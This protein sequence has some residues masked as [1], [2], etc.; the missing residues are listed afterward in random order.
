M[1]ARPFT[2][3]VAS[4]ASAVP[5]AGGRDVGVGVAVGVA[6]AVG[7]GVGVAVGVGVGVGV[8]VAV[9]AASAAGCSVADVDTDAGGA[10]SGGR[11]APYTPVPVMTTAQ[12][13]IVTTAPAA[14]PFSPAQEGRPISSV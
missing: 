1:G 10:A 3:I 4:S 8:V 5:A 7:V 12:A 6:V 14:R 9:A 11:V 13:T 2:G